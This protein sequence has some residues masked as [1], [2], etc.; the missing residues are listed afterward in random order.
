[1]KVV[2]YNNVVPPKNKKPEKHEILSRFIQ[3]VRAVGDEGILHN[4]F[5]IVDADVGVI[6]GWQHEA[7]KTAQHLQ[8]RQNV[9]DT[10][11]LK[12][13][14]VCVADSNLF[15]FANPTNT[16]HHYLRYSFNGVFPN[17][18]IYFD[19]NPDPKRWQQISRDLNVNLSPYKNKGKNIVL[20]LQREGGWSMGKQSIF[21]WTVAVIN[22][23]RQ[24]SNRLIVIRPHPGDK[25]A[26]ATYLPRL[27]Q[28]F[29]YDNSVKISSNTPLEQDL[30]KAWAVVNHNSSSIVGPLIMGYHAFITDPEKS[31][32]KEVADTD[33]SNIESPNEYDRQKWLERISMF[34]WKFSELSDGTAWQHMKNYVRQ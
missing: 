3:G 14:Y 22:N 11:I 21:D 26:V 13:K 1:M 15:L 12:K 17:T 16:P 25:R 31:Q 34:H 5:T 9:I 28:H 27:A 29:K 24:H 4:G 7:G 33:F 10:Q 30:Q 32:C 8:L 19:D 20:C 6:Q 18:G 23:I 2:S